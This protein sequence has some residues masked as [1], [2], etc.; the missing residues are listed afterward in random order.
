MFCVWQLKFYDINESMLIMC[1][2]IVLSCYH[3]LFKAYSP[4]HM[5]N[6]RAVERHLNIKRGYKRF[7]IKYNA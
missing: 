5:H 4:F 7:D 2:Y 6:I 1:T 3:S